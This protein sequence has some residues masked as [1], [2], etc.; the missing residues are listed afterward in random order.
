MPSLTRPAPR[1]AA[2]ASFTT[3]AG[4]AFFSTLALAL[5]AQA[6]LLNTVSVNLIA[7]AGI[8]SDA[9]P[10]TLTQTAPVP[11]GI[12][13]TNLGGSGAISNYMLDNERISFS[14]DSILIRV[15]AG[16]IDGLHSGYGAGA[17]YEISGIGVLASMIT[18][19][20]VY[21]FDGFVTAGP[22]PT[23]LAAGLVAG[24]FVSSSP[25]FDT[26]SLMLDDALVFR[27]RGLGGS[28]NYAEFRIDLVSQLIPPPPPPPP[29][30]NP[31]P[32]PGSLAL[33]AVAGLG[34]LASQR[35]RAGR[36]G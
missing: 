29:P 34:L 23:G 1:P 6:S 14:G 4:A 5:P 27:D 32:E 22:A 10:F 2:R 30:P 19:Y 8:E 36:G 18:G 16:S 28:Y 24:N 25:T 33:V 35:R 20:N 31:V 7:P 26:F 11:A 3:L 9:T 15:G 12:V 21:G 13:A 17:H